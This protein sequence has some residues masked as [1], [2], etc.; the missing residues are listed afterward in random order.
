MFEIRIHSL[1]KQQPCRPREYSVGL[2]RASEARMRCVFCGSRGKHYRDSCTR[3]RDSKR[4]KLLLKRD[5][6]CN[7]CL[8][9]DCPATEDCPKFWV[10]CFHCEQ[11]GHH[12][13]ICSKPDISQRLQDDIDEALV[14]LQQTRSQVDSIRRKLGM[15]TL[16][17]SPTSPR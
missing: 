11:M 5:N 6:R 17:F 3:D 12:S 4:R 1:Q 16:P 13:A 8:Q 14:E 10:F 2:D 7:M 15:E 9:M